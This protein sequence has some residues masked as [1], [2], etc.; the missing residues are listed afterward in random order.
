MKR[1]DYRIEIDLTVSLTMTAKGGSEYARN[2]PQ[3]AHRTRSVAEITTPDHAAVI[4][5]D[6]GR[7][8][9]EELAELVGTELRKLIDQDERHFF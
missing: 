2:S 8:T 3:H 7:T 9:A 1:T 4:A 6:I 5:R